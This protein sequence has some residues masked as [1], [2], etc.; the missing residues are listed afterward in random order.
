MRTILSSL[1]CLLVTASAASAAP[2][3][4]YRSTIGTASSGPVEA[5]VWL[6]LRDRSTFDALVASQYNAHSPNYRKWLTFNQIAARFGPS[7]Y[8]T[9]RVRQFLAQHGM[10]VVRTGPGNLY[11]RAR[12]SVAAA[13]NA[14]HTRLQNV[15]IGTSVR[16]RAA[17][18]PQVDPDVA[19]VVSGVSGLE[20]AT[21]A[22]LVTQ[23]PASGAQHAVPFA[24]GPTDAANF[25]SPQ[26]FLPPQT[27]TVVG[28]GAFDHVSDTFAGTQLNLPG[29]G[30]AYGCSQTPQS[31][32]KA[33]D[34]GGLY[35]E[36]YTGTGQ[37]LAI[38]LWCGVS[39]TLQ[40]DANAF[41]LFFGLPQ[42]TR[43]QNYFETDVGR[44]SCA[45]DPNVNLE[46]HLD[47]EWAHAVAPGAWLNVVLAH[48][49]QDQDI[50]EAEIDAIAQSLGT[51]ISGSFAGIE[52]TTPTADVDEFNLTSEFAAARGI[53]TNFGSGD[54]GDYFSFEYGAQLVSTPADSPYATAIGGETLAL[55]SNSSVAWESGWGNNVSALEIN[56]YV[57]GW[58]LPDGFSYGSGGGVSNCVQHTI[59][60]SIGQG[61][62]V[63]CHGGY[64]KPGFQGAI[65]GKWRSLPDVS[66][67]AD[68]TTGVLV[69]SSSNNVLYWQPNIG[70]TS[71][72]TPMFSALWAIANQESADAGG[73]PLGQAAP[74]LYKMPAGTIQDIVPVGS[75]SS[76]TAAITQSGVTTTYSPVQL[77]AYGDQGPANAQYPEFLTAFYN[78]SGGSVLVESF[79]ADCGDLGAG[80]GVGLL[81]CLP[82]NES[83]LVGVVP[84]QTAVGWDDVT[85]VGR[86]IGKAFADAFH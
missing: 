27:K 58:P 7:A 44:Q 15:R 62:S 43:N 60:G 66:W 85:G 73:P 80:A 26:C 11:V 22:P 68:P 18:E 53:S 81:E 28:S 76:V 84:L 55:N 83:H 65:A 52:G 59:S 64:P 23:L 67:L 48:S 75:S 86:P 21:V 78:I 30:I 46:L 24:L 51:V 16:L 63:A 37:T 29:P 74:Y 77:M 57:E 14:F 56:K 32:R 82:T 33:Y 12:G 13:E 40:S 2:A 19:G 36:G 6:R 41:S 71:V 3:A 47:V 42:L 39:P 9:L 34:L 38:L 25:W 50:I 5:T 4:S 79:G 10:S 1:F 54:Y 69:L 31:V 61:Y 70:G 20:G 45:I 17:M 8:D 72:A 35:G 49:N